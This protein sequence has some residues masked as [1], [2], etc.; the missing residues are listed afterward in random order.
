[1]Y[2]ATQSS[3]KHRAG[4]ATVASLALVVALTA[5]A[6]TPDNADK[7][8]LKGTTQSSYEDW[9]LEFEKCMRAEGVELHSSDAG[10]EGSFGT[11]QG[12]P[13]L[14]DEAQ[15]T[16]IANV[17]EPP[18]QDGEQSSTE[19]DEIMLTFAQCMREAGYNYPDPQPADGDSS[20]SPAIDTAGVDPAV[21][22]A[23]ATKAGLSEART[24][25]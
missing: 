21:L 5:C 1:M 6:P 4:W 25:E 17:G 12:D 15:E 3:R 8:E 14:L 10:S 19:T 24:A 11:A 23:C 18:V 13:T 16:C 9:S 20:L 7:E 22:D 2:T